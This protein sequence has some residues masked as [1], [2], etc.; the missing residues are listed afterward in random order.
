MTSPRATTTTCAPTMR[1]CATVLP[2]FATLPSTAC[3]TTMTVAPMTCAISQPMPRLLAPIPTSPASPLPYAM[4]LWGVTRPK[5]A[6][7]PTSLALAATVNVSSLHAILVRAVLLKTECVLSRILVA[8]PPHAHLPA[9]AAAPADKN[10]S[11]TG[12]S[13]PP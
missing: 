9:T 11:P 1:A 2:S 3:A 12:L 7:L 8:T 10:H 6:C 4:C 5:G 13:A